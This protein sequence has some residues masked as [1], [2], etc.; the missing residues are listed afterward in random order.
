MPYCQSHVQHAQLTINDI[1]TPWLCCN[2]S[3]VHNYKSMFLSTPLLRRGAANVLALRNSDDWLHHGAQLLWSRIDTVDRQAMHRNPSL[4]WTLM[5]LGSDF[6]IVVLSLMGSLAERSYLLFEIC[7]AA[8]CVWQHWQ[9]L[10]TAVDH[11]RWRCKVISNRRR[12][13]RSSSLTQ[14]K[15]MKIRIMFI[16]NTWFY[17]FISLE[18]LTVP[19]S[20]IALCC[21]GILIHFTHSRRWSQHH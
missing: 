19:R 2:V 12:R 6:L 16:L 4:Q 5:S 13:F 14:K 1:D 9:T 20:S 15:Q 21:I 11:Q 7:C 18:N 3:T 17:V 10:R 8:A